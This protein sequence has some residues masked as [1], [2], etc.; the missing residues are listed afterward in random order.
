M[1]DRLHLPLVLFVV[2]ASCSRSST[3]TEAAPAPAQTAPPKATQALV[4]GHADV[5]ADP[6][7]P[8]HAFLV[9]DAP[10]QLGGD[11]LTGTIAL[12]AHGNVVVAEDSHSLRAWDLSTGVPTLELAPIDLDPAALTPA[13]ALSP[14]GKW[15]AI[16]AT[17]GSRIMGFAAGALA[18]DFNANCI[19]P[20]AFSRDSKLFL[21][22][23]LLVEVWSVDDHKLVAK[24]PDEGGIKSPRAVQFTT[25]NKAVVRVTDHEIVRWDI[26]SKVVTSIY[27]STDEITSAALSASGSHAF[28]SSHPPSTYKRTA[29]LVDLA[30]GKTAPVGDAYSAAVSPSG[31]RVAVV[32]GAEVRVLEG[33]KV[34]WSGKGTAPVQRLAFT[35]DSDDVLAYVEGGRIHVVDVPKGE[36]TYASPSR[37]AGWVAEGVIATQR[38]GKL[39]QLDL[40]KNTWTTLDKPPV[41]TVTGAPAWATWLAAGV[42]AAPPAGDKCQPKLRVWTPA[43]G[44]KTISA[45]C[46][47]NS[48]G[49]KLG[50]RWVVAVANAVATV[51]DP[52]T[53]KSLGALPVEKPYVDRPEFSR[54]YVGAALAPTALALLSR[55]P[56]VSQGSGDPHSD[57]L[58]QI[59]PKC[60][61]DLT[62]EC[63]QQY[64]VTLYSLDKK[65]QQSWQLAVTNDR[66]TELAPHAAEIAIDHAGKRVLVGTEDGAILIASSARQTTV[67]RKHLSQIVRIVVSPGDAW[68]FSEDASGVQR[69]WKLP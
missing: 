35:S 66:S 46:T 61:V 60:E 62:G 43:G 59:Q 25:D 51:F 20:R 19:T 65:P 69:V 5:R 40:A 45:P 13:I 41:D 30:T 47:E 8:S 29:L 6:A 9:G 53:G 38:D 49:W 28:V 17:K 4:L 64:F 36:R 24:A 68:A 34:V 37:F 50:S 58:H 39:E 27:K 63:W 33:A 1:I 31:S 18:K 2:G 67:E 23:T 54:Q 32:A 55:G 3:T 26:G 56:Q 7:A 11:G 16:G 15:A 14:D 57:S 22:N 21:C 48:P 10:L 42:A 52:A 12:S 44:D